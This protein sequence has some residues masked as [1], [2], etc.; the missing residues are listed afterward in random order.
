MK[1]SPS[2]KSGIAR[3]KTVKKERLY[4]IGEIFRQKLLLNHDGVPYTD[5]STI[6]RI[7][8]GMQATRVPTAWGQGYA[9]PLSA[10]HRHNAGHAKGR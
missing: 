8:R 9:V 4:T 3:T 1:K 5:K 10:I 2:K 6:S 7:V